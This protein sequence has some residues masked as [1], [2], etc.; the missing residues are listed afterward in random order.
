MPSPIPPMKPYPRYTSHSCVVAMPR[1]PIRKPVHQKQ[2]A[3]NIALRG[4]TRSTQVP[5]TAAET[6]SITMAIEKMMP[7][8]VR[9][10]SKCATSAVLYTLV[11]YACPIQRWMARAAGGIS[12]RLYPGFATVCS[13]SR[14]DSAAM[15]HLRVLPE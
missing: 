11:A 15:T 3:V 6:P 1:E 10:V 12:H 5:I 8:A 13:R 14:N 9:L 4:P 2:A 7:I